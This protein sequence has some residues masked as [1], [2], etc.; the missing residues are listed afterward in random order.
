M[1]KIEFRQQVVAV[2]YDEELGANSLSRHSML[3]AEKE[4]LSVAKEYQPK[5]TGNSGIVRRESLGLTPRLLDLFQVLVSLDHDRESCKHIRN[6]LT[7]VPMIS[8][9]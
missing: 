4:A 8:Q 3:G 6:K 9:T 1:H 7:S 5:G 2:P